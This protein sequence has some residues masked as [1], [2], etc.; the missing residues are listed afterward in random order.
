M[1]LI[2]HISPEED[3]SCLAISSFASNF[4]KEIHD[5][6]LSYQGQRSYLL[7]NSHFGINVLNKNLWPSREIRHRLACFPF[8]KSVSRTKD[9]SRKGLSKRNGDLEIS[10]AAAEKFNSPKSRSPHDSSTESISKAKTSSRG[11]LRSHGPRNPCLGLQ[12]LDW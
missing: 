10:E 2:I 5:F 6:F 11:I 12:R 7:R 9:P 1:F 8:R 3:R 4:E